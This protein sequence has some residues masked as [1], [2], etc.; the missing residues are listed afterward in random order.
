MLP[1][2]HLGNAVHTAQTPGQQQSAGLLGS[3][4]KRGMCVWLLLGSCVSYC[5]PQNSIQIPNITSSLFLLLAFFLPWALSAAQAIGPTPHSGPKCLELWGVS[6]SV[7]LSEIGN[8]A[9]Q[10]NGSRR[11]PQLAQAAPD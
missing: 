4:L 7:L 10:A 8:T 11:W 3:G 6:F 1:A 5:L 2:A 9:E